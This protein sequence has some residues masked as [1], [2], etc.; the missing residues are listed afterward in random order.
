MRKTCIRWLRCR[1]RAPLDSESMH[2]A[3]RRIVAGS[4]CYLGVVSAV[5]ATRAPEPGLAVTF[6]VA[7]V[8]LVGASMAIAIRR[9]EDVA[10]QVLQALA[11]GTFALTLADL[12]ARDPFAPDRYHALWIPSVL[13][14]VA[15]AARLSK[16]QAPSMA[17]SRRRR[18]H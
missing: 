2:R 16:R 5:A 7:G 15:V 10:V 8:A 17:A 9:S 6:L 1:R 18:H 11:G 4:A 3:L 12:A 14:A 13:G